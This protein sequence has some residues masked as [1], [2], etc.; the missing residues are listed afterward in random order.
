MPTMQKTSS[1]SDDCRLIAFYLPQFHPIPENDQWWGKGFTEWTNVTKAKPL[2]HGHYQP[3]LPADFGFYD[4]RI[5]EIRR[6]QISLAKSYGI[7]G[8]C[9]HYYWFSG[10]RLLEK[11]LDDMLADPDSDMPFCLCWANENWTRRWD[12]RENELLIAQKHEA[13]DDLNF[14][15]DLVPFITDSRYIC[16]DGAPL[17]IVYHPQQMP[18][19]VASIKVWRDYCASIGIE[20]IHVACAFTHGTWTKGRG[21]DSGVEFPPHNVVVQNNSGEL[22]FYDTFQGMCP[23]FA[24]I[25][26]F[27]LDLDHD[28]EFQSVFKTVF[29][30]W[31]NTSRRKNRSL[32]TLN[33][34]P[35]NYQTWLGRTIDKTRKNYPGQDRLVFINAWNEWAEGCHLEPDRTYGHAFL[36]ATLNAKNGNYPETWS[37]RGIPKACKTA[38]TTISYYTGRNKTAKKTPL[39]RGFRVL[40]DTLNGRRFKKNYKRRHVPD[41]VPTRKPDS[42]KP[43]IFMHIQKTAGTSLVSLARKKYGQEDVSSHD[44]FAT[45]PD[46]R[47]RFI[48]GHFGYQ[49]AQRFR[50]HRFLFTFLR[51]PDKRLISLYNFCRNRDPEQFL[52]YRLAQEHEFD[53]FLRICAEKPGGKATSEQVGLYEQVWNNMTWQ[54]A[55]GWGAG[56]S[57]LN[58]EPDVLLEMAKTNIQCFDFVGFHETFAEDA[59]YVVKKLGIEDSE[60]PN[61]NV[62]K[63]LV[64]K[65]DLPRETSELIRS[66]TALDRELYDYA[67]GLRRRNHWHSNAGGT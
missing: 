20:K 16:I 40:R 15:K 4:L 10:R 63:K 13:G 57:V 31:D 27:Y 36:Q 67:L 5:P 39:K 60:I 8:F 6:E 65:S 46:S 38:P 59:R 51:E 14:I 22:S 56:S 54:S 35:E 64:K 55:V 53:A 34:T 45:R 18:D 17:I 48:S 41:A 12:A 49:Y 2:F 21:F 29:P 47:G 23:D 24:D 50:Q 32:I 52:I 7:D 25:A 26:E 19:P 37:H 1:G 9:Y 30:S 43:A 11:P 28:E 33:G 42:L 44:D 66:L 61:A 58:H 3:H 62:S